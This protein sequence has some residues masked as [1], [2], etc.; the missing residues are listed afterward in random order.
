[1]ATYNDSFYM[2]FPFRSFVW[3]H[4]KRKYLCY[5]CLFIFV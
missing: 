5:F 1:M 4:C 3:S 2:E